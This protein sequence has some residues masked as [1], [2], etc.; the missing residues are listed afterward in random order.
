MMTARTSTPL[1]AGTMA[2]PTARRFTADAM[3]GW[4]VAAET[5]ETAELVVSELVGNAVQHGD[6]ITELGL[7]LGEDAV[8][9]EVADNNQVLPVMLR[10]E[11]AGD[12]HRGLLIVAALSRDWGA[13]R[14]AGG[15]TVWAELPRT[16]ADH[17]SR[18]LIET[19]QE[20]LS[21][22]GHNMT[23]IVAGPTVRTPVAE[24]A[25]TG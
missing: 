22:V 9:I 18:N 24:R 10:P 2:V 13:R 17:A 12:R 15:K 1:P 16:S 14:D 23:R 11:P 7:T 21:G 19:P 3:Q 4:P 20:P 5:R 25:P 8:R 6:G